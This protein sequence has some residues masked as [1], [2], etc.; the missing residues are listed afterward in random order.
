[1]T[2]G[3]QF[4]ITRTI[5]SNN[6]RSGQ[7]QFLKQNTFLTGGFNQIEYFGSIKISIA[8]SNWDVENYR[9]KLKKFWPTFGKFL[10]D[11]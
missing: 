8:K 1:M 6:E 9:N 3:Q 7:F 5:Y 2:E 10:A 4:E 11:L